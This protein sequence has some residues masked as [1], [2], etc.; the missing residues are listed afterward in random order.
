MP[1]RRMG[2]LGLIVTLLFALTLLAAPGVRA[3]AS[4]DVTTTGTPGEYLVEARG[5]D[6]SERVSTWLTGPNQEVIASD[7]QTMNGQGD[8]DFRLRIPRFFQAGRWAITLHGLSSNREAIAFFDVPVR[9]PDVP[10]AITP[11]RTGPGGS[12][13][14]TSVGFAANEPIS[15]WLTGPDGQTSPGGYAMAL[16]DGRVEFPYTVDFSLQPGLWVMS[17]YGT[18]SDHLGVAFFAV[19]GAGSFAQSPFGLRPEESTSAFYNWYV[20]YPGGALTSGAYKTS[21]FLTDA[22]K[23]KIEQT[24][25]DNGA[26]FDPVVCATS[27]PLGIR[28]SPA[29]INADLARVEV[30]T[31]LP[32]S[33][34]VQLRIVEG[35]W[36]LDAIICPTG[37]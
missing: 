1:R 26:G 18:N 21:P 32:N 3:A 24:V 8:K 20:T 2:R 37:A 5:F 10:L 19:V 29:T 23:Q 6:G 4:V 16:A 11:S 36:K 22:L 15:Y 14:V 34:A 28:T 27:L 31:D 35:Q 13:T 12:V 17:I 30:Q 33:F 7:R 25:A 9:R